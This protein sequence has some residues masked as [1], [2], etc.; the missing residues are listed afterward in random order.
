MVVGWGIGVRRA[1]VDD[2]MLVLCVN[3]SRSGGGISGMASWIGSDVGY[4]DAGV[5]CG[6]ES[7]GGGWLNE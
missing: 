5:G 1:S 6:V 3:H 4:P 2:A 7:L